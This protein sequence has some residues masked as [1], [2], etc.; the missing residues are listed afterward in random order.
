MGELGV[1]TGA[2]GTKV[3]DAEGRGD[4]CSGENND[5]LAG[6]K[7]MNSVV[8]RV[9]LGQLCSLLELP[10]EG[11]YEEAVVAVVVGALEERRRADAKSCKKFL[12]CYDAG[13]YSPLAKDLGANRTQ[14]LAVLNRFLWR[15]CFGVCA[16]RSADVSGCKNCTPWAE[17]ETTKPTVGNDAIVSESANCVLKQRFAFPVVAIQIGDAFL[18]FTH[19]GVGNTMLNILLNLSH[20]LL[21]I[22]VDD[23]SESGTLFALSDTIAILAIGRL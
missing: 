6:L 17:R 11:E 23:I 21:L 1:Q 8:N 12:G 2:F 19:V 3:R 22:I 4:S 13:V 5:V 14:E 7:E 10:C 16:V 15:A 18:K 9:I 20:V